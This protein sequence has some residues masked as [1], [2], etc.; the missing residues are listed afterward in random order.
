MGFL[1]RFYITD[2][3]HTM[4]SYLL[5]PTVIILLLLIV[6]AIYCIGSFVIEL[7]TDR[8]YYRVVIP[9]IIARVNKASPKD[10]SDVIDESGLLRSQKD[11]LDELISYLYLP[12]DSRTEVA[13]RLL[14]NED[15]ANQKVLE[16]TDL[17]ARVAPMLGLM[18]TLIPLGPGIVALGSG[19]T[20]TLSSSLL[21]A[22]DTTVMGLTTAVVC[23]IVSRVRRRW[24]EDYL[25]S[26]ESLM[27]A[28]L[29]KATELHEQGYVFE[30]S[31]YTYDKTGRSA[32][33]ES[34]GDESEKREEDHGGGL[35]RR[36]D[37]GGALA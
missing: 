30:Q 37:E 6:Y 29:E 17:A 15:V 11:D 9:E 32:K 33:W 16:R 35:G 3:M 23:F 7:V 26:M 24:Y 20:E 25:V 5:I 4:S 13:R 1:D 8:R 21:V 19:D 28:I 31:M 18:G 36:V 22:F 2:I 14:S 10:L 34:L 27:N 12:E